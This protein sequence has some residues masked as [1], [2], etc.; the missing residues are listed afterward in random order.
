MASGAG[1]GCAFEASVSMA[2]YAGG[3]LMCA[4]ERE[5]G[6]GVIKSLNDVLLS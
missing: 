1:S 4:S 5:S 2:G 3:G 6:P